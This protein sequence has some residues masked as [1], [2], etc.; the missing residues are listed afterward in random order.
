MLMP[1]EPRIVPRKEHRISRKQVSP[2][3]L[4][5]LYR[6][7]SRGFMAYLVG[8]C[9]RDLLLGRTPKDFDIGTNATP[10]QIKRLF[11]NCR[12]VGRRFRLAHLRFQDEIVEVSTF[13]RSADPSDTVEPDETT[14][15]RRHVRHMKD[16]NGMVLADNIFGTPEEDALRRDFTINALAYNIADAS[17]VDYCMGLADLKDRLIRSIGDPRVRFTEDPVRM[18]RAVR[19]AASHGF[20]I[21]TTAWESIRELSSTISRASP[22][23]LYEELQKL[24]LLGFARPTFRLLEESGLL[25]SLFPGLAGWVREKET[26][27][28]ALDRNLAGVDDLVGSGQ[29]VSVALFLAALFGPRMEETA[30]AR[31]REG[32]P[33]RQALDETCASFL[34]EISRSAHIPGRVAGRL[35]SIIALKTSLCRMPPRRPSTLA[36]RPEFTEALTYLGLT[37]GTEG[38]RD[39]AL[40]WWKTFL[41]ENPPAESTEAPAEETPRKKRRRRRRKPRRRG[42]NIVQEEGAAHG[43]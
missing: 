33:R 40:T 7:Y 32:I 39:E 19:F 34:E 8:G 15:D 31:H 3:A 6:L 5:T 2:N 24:F 25:A 35:N 9:V 37:A 41:L 11:H 30:L 38:E 21:E 13:R 17:V 29:G 10:G 20:D 1:M 43:R 4:R 26:H 42:E 23:R 18:L 22:S 16:A 14:R 28:Q 12:L 27:F 36:G